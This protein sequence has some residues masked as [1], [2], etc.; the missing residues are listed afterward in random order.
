MRPRWR[1]R[2]HKPHF[3][4]EPV[5]TSFCASYQLVPPSID[6]F[7]IWF[8]LSY[9]SMSASKSETTIGGHGSA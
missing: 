1:F 6:H 8:S 3:F 5:I 9:R 7:L 4:R 2:Q